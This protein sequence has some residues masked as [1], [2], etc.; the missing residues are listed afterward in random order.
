MASMTMADL[1]ANQDQKNLKLSRNQ[2]VEGEIVLITESDVILDLGTKSEGVFPKKDLTPAQASSLKVGDKLRAFV[3]APENESG[4]V[5][6]SAQRMVGK[7]TP[8]FARFQRFEEAMSSHR[9]MVGKGLEVNKGGLIVEVGGVRGFLPSSQVSLTAA[10]N[11]ESL[12]GKDVSVSVIEVD[13]NQN[14]LIFSQK[15]M[16][17]D[18]VKAKLAKLKIGDKVEG[19][20]AAVLAFGVF[21]NLK[22]EEYQGVEGLAHVSELAWERVEDPNTLFK[23]GQEIKAEI[24]SIDTETGRVN[25]SIRSLTTDPYKA[26]SEKY[27][28]DDVVKATV[29]KVSGNTVTFKLEEGVEATMTLNSDSEE[30]YEEGQTASVLIDNVDTNKHKISVAPFRTSTKDLIYK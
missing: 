2:E 4:Q 5:V 11:L 24:I 21:A 10:A 28:A 13:Q 25:L 12:I 17:S 19:V 16:V 18:E 23:V 7:V 15:G 20:V 22:G 29:S 8:G 1:L 3:I 30:K 27:Q 26:L 9:T 14:R 6:L